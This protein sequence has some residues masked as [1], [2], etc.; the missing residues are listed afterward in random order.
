MGQCDR[1]GGGGCLVPR[2]PLGEGYVLTLHFEFS[3]YLLEL[4]ALLIFLSL[5]AELPTSCTHYSS[6]KHF[7]EAAYDAFISGCVFVIMA[8]ILG[9][10]NS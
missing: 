3:I 7:H 2:I 8:R 5:Y 6:G 9:K 4:C 10:R 1:N